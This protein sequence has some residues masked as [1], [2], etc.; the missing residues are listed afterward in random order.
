MIQQL[1]TQRDAAAIGSM[2]QLRIAQG[3]LDNAMSTLSNRT[4]KY[5]T[6]PSAHHDCRR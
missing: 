4:A 2:E 6:D 1:T 3:A 5:R